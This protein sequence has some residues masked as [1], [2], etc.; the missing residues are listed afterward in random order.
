MLENTPCSK[1]YVSPFLQVGTLVLVL[2]PQW[3]TAARYTGPLGIRMHSNVAG[4]TGW[5]Y[6]SDSDGE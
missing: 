2:L 3:G 4:V 5:G 6:S 1:I